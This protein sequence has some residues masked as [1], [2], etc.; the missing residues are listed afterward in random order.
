M[1]SGAG[2]RAS[3]TIRR[4]PIFFFFLWWLSGPG[5]GTGPRGVD[6]CDYGA[7]G[8]EDARRVCLSRLNGIG[9]G[10][11]RDQALADDLGS[12]TGAAGSGGCVVVRVGMGCKG[13]VGENRAGGGPRSLGALAGDLVVEFETDGTFASFGAD[14]FPPA[15]MGQTCA[16]PSLGATYG[17]M[18]APMPGFCE[19]PGG[20]M[21]LP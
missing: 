1:W 5:R 2:A 18:P 15:G 14:P 19:E 3:P 16:T 12:S 21:G 7:P 11:M 20:F 17:G 9:L 6:E 4:G 10:N 13:D 8:N